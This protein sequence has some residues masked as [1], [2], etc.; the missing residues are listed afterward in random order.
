MPKDSITTVNI[1]PSDWVA[2]PVDT[3]IW[4]GPAKIALIIGNVSLRAVGRNP[5]YPHQDG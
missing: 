2:L 1:R 4:S 5:A 3:R